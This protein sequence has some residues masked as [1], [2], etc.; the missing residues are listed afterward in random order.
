MK[1][2]KLSHENIDNISVI[3]NEEQI[4]FDKKELG[5]NEKEKLEF[6]LYANARRYPKVKS[7]IVKLSNS[8]FY[9]TSHSDGK[10]IFSNYSNIESFQKNSN[11]DSKLRYKKLFYTLEPPEIKNKKNNLLVVFSSVS[12]FPYNANIERRNFFENFK[13]IRKYIPHN[14]YILRISDIGGVVGSFYLNNNF[15]DEV[16]STIQE[17]L[18]KVSNDLSIE[19]KD[20]VL[21]GVSKGGTA[22]LYHGILGGYKCVAVDPIVCDDYHQKNHNDS[23]FTIGTFPQSKKNK[24]TELMTHDIHKNVNIIYSQNSPIFNDIETIIK[25]N[26]KNNNINLFN[27][28]HPKIKSHPDVG[29]NTINILM[30]IINNLFYEFY[31]GNANVRIKNE[32]PTSR[33]ILDH[34]IKAIK[35]K[36]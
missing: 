23:H 25:S 6:N 17:L 24:F 34:L 18:I 3:G 7:L 27:I 16:E 35:N 10:S 11:L 28:E 19:N 2:I 1:T 4:A 5:E 9:M 22:S 20:I 26:D 12:D 31:D 33:K 8:G 32:W 21:Y 14:T 36:K 29:P 30:L 15:N 13:T